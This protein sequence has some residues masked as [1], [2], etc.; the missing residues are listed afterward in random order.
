MAERFN[1]G[2]LLNTTLH[3]ESDGSAVLE[4][5]MDAQTIIDA[6]AAERNHRFSGASPG[7]TVHAYARIPETEALKWAREAGLGNNI[8]G[9]EFEIV[10]ELQLKKPENAYMLTAP[11]VRDPRII[12]KGNR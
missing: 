10:M 3:I 6:N 1:L 5:K 11:T 7:G 4:E 8:Y 9:R 2:G 12:I